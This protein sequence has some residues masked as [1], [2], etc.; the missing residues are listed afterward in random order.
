MCKIGYTPIS[1][2]FKNKF[3][4]CYCIE[5]CETAKEQIITLKQYQQTKIT[6]HFLKKCCAS[7]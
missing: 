5:F 6:S 2:L 1:M 7:I 4:I 3:L